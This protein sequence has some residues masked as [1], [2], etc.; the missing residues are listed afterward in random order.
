[1]QIINLEIGQTIMRQGKHSQ[2]PATV[3]GKSIQSGK[4]QKV[5]VVLYFGNAP[6]FESYYQVFN[7]E[8]TIEVLS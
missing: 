6:V 7:G 5:L 3:M 2:F 4:G 1:M 8:S